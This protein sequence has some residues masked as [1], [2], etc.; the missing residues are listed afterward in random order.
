MDKRAHESCE[1][2]DTPR[3][4][5]DELRALHEVAN[6]LSTAPSL[7]DLCRRAV[8]LGQSRLGFDRL[9]IW[10]VS[11]DG[12]AVTGTFGVDEGG[13]IRD[14]RGHRVRVAPDSVMGQILTHKA[15]SVLSEDTG[16]Y[17]DRGE[18]VGRGTMAGSA[19]WDGEKAI[20][21]IAIDNLLSR[22]PITQQQCELLSLYGSTLGHL[23]SRQRALD[24]LRRSEELFRMVVDHSY[25]GINISER[26]IVANKT[27]RKLVYCNQ[28]FVEMSGYSREALMA[29]EDLNELVVSAMSK[30]ERGDRAERLRRGLPVHGVSSWKRPDGKPNWHEWV[31]APLTIDA[32]L[33]TVGIDR[34]VTE[35][36]RAEGELRR[37]SAAVE[38]AAE[39]IVVTDTEAAI[40]YVNPA[41]EQITGYTRDEAIG[42][43]PRVLKSGQHDDAFY[44]RMWD[45]LKRGDVWR[46]H[47]VNRRKDGTLYEEDA[48]ISPV[49]DASGKT[50]NYVAVKRDVTQQIRLEARLRQTQKMEAIGTLAGGIAH[51]FNNLLTG[52]LGYANALKLQSRPG[53]DVFQSA[54]VIQKAAERAAAL[55]QGLLGFARKGKH[56]NVPVDLH[57]T[58]RE[59]VALLSR[60]I[61]NKNIAITQRF[62]TDT[63][64]VNGDPTQMQQVLLNLGI[65]AC[66]AMPDGGELVF[67]TDTADLDEQ[68]CADHP[69]ATP[70]PHLQLSVTDTGRGIPRGIQDRI[71]EPFFTTKEMGGGTGMGLATVYGI[72]KNHGGAVRV[73][74]EVGHGT[75]LKVYLPLPTT[76]AEAETPSADGQATRGEGRI[77]LVDDEEVVRNIGA[78]LLSDLGY[79]VTAVSGGQDA[80]DHYR[81]HHADIDLVILDMIMPGM[82]GSDCFRA[83]RE[84]D[85]EVRAILSTGYG[86]NGEAHT[87]LDQGMVGLL[88]KPYSVADLSKAVADALRR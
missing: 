66:D 79:H 55:A 52:I 33:H 32:K 47:F 61:T 87:A 86:L 49:R 80:I 48:A 4:P 16:L 84:I 12:D 44:R 21:R 43:N 20:G 41:F 58:V 19:L 23:C 6:E 64:I 31:A 67:A 63:A 85:P 29:Y 51:D 37:L 65:N 15:P 73:Y 74:S 71:F 8:E 22:K 50:V 2:D 42:Q 24:E 36:M 68:Y 26:R 72:V 78:R 18:V 9:S 75:V 17:N 40:Q 35:R 11:E 81:A 30:A 53:E 60:T 27:P 3:R 45:T 1:R 28:R 54:D 38:Q 62:G 10:F 39:T 25:D 70:G 83:L 34:D 56:Q 14:E 13:R 7:D 82:G 88:Q 59:V 46:G 57:D 69:G 77:L 76:P 5:Q